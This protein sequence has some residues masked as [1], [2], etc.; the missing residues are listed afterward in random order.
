M[1]DTAALVHDGV[2]ARRKWAL[3]V[4]AVVFVTGLAFTFWWCSVVDHLRVW[5]D[6][7]DLWD[8]YRA[9]QW[10]GWGNEGTVYQHGIYSIV[11]PGIDVLLAPVAM[12]S[13]HFRLVDPYPYFVR[14]PSALPLLMPYVLAISVPTLLVFD[15]LAEYPRR[16]S[17]ATHCIYAGSRACSCGR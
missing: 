4:A 17:E 12:V 10:V 11:F 15:Y 16:E 2:V 13:T 14:R 6:S 1:G 7:G 5:A 9:A 8:T 3:L